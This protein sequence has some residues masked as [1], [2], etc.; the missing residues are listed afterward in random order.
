[1]FELIILIIII[2]VIYK[3]SN[4]IMTPEK[5]KIILKNKGF[6]N[7]TTIRQIV[8]GTWITA[9]YHG[10]NYIFYLAKTGY[11]ISKEAVVAIYNYASQKHYHNIILVPITSTILT[12]ARTAISNYG[13]QI[14]NNDMLNNIS[15]TSTDNAP[16]AIIQKAPINDNCEI[17]EPVDP[18]QDGSKANSIFQNLFGNKIERL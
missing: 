4:L 16:S 5:F 2:Y 15:K 12:N 17:D 7:M 14:W 8:S 1:M 9:D 18:I 11:S 10:D 3:K 6:R 13:I